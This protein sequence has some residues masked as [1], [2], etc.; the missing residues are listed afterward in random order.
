MEASQTIKANEVKE[1]LLNKDKID[2]QLTDKSHHDDSGQL[3]YLREKSN[4]ESF[5]DNS[6]HRSLM[7]NYCHKKGHIRVDYW[8]QKKKQ[9]DTSVV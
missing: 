6:K 7:S 2:T 8:T 9:P 5:K 3:Y 1:H 4:N